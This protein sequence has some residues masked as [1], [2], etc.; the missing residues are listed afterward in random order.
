MDVTKLLAFAVTGAICAAIL[1]RTRPEFAMAVGLLAVTA[2][3]AAAV[4]SL[5]PVLTLLRQLTDAIPDGR[6]YLTVLLKCAGAATLSSVA[7][8]LCADCGETALSKTAATVGRVAVL[9]A[10]LPVFTDLADAAVAL[11]GG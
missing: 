11:I 8:D 3:M 2:A 6:I 7:A 9:V 5:A 4:A 10:A 1:K